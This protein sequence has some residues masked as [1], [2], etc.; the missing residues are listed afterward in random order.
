MERVGGDADNTDNI[1]MRGVLPVA[2]EVHAK[3]QVV[4][5]TKLN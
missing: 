3:V 4:A 2:L 1:V 5:G